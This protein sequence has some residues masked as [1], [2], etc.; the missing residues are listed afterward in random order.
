MGLVEIRAD[1]HIHTS[2]SPCSDTWRMTP[3]AIV[4]RARGLELG[5][6]AVCDHNSMRNVEAVQRAAKGSGVVVL[7]GMEITSWEEVH[8][9]GIFQA[10]EGAWAMQAFVDENLPGENIPEVFGY[11]VLMDENDEIVGSEDRLLAGATTLK[12][13]EVVEAIH[14][15]GGLAIASHVDREG[16]GIIGQLGWIPE[17]LS[18]DALEVSW[19][20]TRPEARQRFPEISKWP[21]LRSSDAHSPEEIG[22]AWTRLLVSQGTWAELKMALKGED[23]R[24][25]L[26]GS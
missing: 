16:F 18:L 15:F 14:R 17:T 8:I 11:Q 19:A 26:G 3:R 7:P 23:G 25:V 2:L 9:L 1:L 4:E 12:V 24:R 20:M 5:M 13:E 21:L 22:R 10:L 6:I